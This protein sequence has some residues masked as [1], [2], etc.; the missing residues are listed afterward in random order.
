MTRFTFAPQT[1]RAVNESAAPADSQVHYLLELTCAELDRQSRITTG[2]PLKSLQLLEVNRRDFSL[3]LI[4][5]AENMMGRKKMVLK[6]VVHHS[7]NLQITKSSNQA[8]VEFEILKQLHHHFQSLERCAVPCPIAVFPDEEAFVMEYVEGDLLSKQLDAARHWVLPVRFKELEKSY[9]SLGEWLKHFQSVT[10]MEYGGSEIFAG[11]LERCESR[12]QVIADCPLFRCSK[13]FVSR[14]LAY[15]RESVSDL[16]GHVIPIAGRHGDLG[17]W[18]IM[19]NASGVTVFDFLGY[20]KEPTA[21]DV[22]KV[23]TRLQAL[24]SKPLN[25]QSRIHRLQEQFLNGYGAVPPTPVPALALCE[26]YHQICTIAGC[27]A[28]P[29]VR[30]DYRLWSRRLLSEGVE[31][32]GRLEQVMRGDAVYVPSFLEALNGRPSVAREASS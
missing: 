11:V 8:V 6:K 2:S 17:D 21:Y 24:E 19:V 27:I 28:N 25:N 30:V 23:L 16:S 32:V 13:G 18:N 29:G 10:G 31:F 9:F 3:V 15:L 1:A 12:L 22:L 5:L 7:V 4:V 14:T 26:M 20:G